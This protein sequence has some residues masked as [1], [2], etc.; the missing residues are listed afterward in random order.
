MDHWGDPWA[1]DSDD[2]N[3][4]QSPPKRDKVTEAIDSPPPTT[5][6]APVLLNAFLDDAQWGDPEED[7]DFGGWATSA[8][9]R[10]SNQ[11]DTRANEV[12]A[13]AFTVE[14]DNTSHY[15]SEAPKHTFEVGDEGWGTTNTTSGEEA[16]RDVDNVFSEA[17]D[18]ATTIQPEEPS[19]AI[20]ND[21]AS[22]SVRHGD[23]FSTRPSTS[24]SDTSHRDA[25]VE[26]PRTSFEDERHGTDVPATE[27]STHTEVEKEKDQHE[28]I[29]DVSGSEEVPDEGSEDNLQKV[30]EPELD[31]QEAVAAL[32]QTED[33]AVVSKDVTQQQA[34]QLDDDNAELPPFVI[35][36]NVPGLNVDESLLDK[37]FPPIP[38]LRGLPT[39][40]DDPVHSTSARKAW[41]RLTRK[42][43][44]REFN[45]STDDDNY[46]RITWKQSHIRSEVNKIVGRWATEDRLSG[47]GPA[48]AANFYW[49]QVPSSEP[50]VKSHVRRKSSISVSMVQ[51]SASNSATNIPP[52]F[53][54]SSPVATTNVWTHNPPSSQ[55][56]S[57]TATVKDSAPS[58]IRQ[59]D[60]PL[61]FSGSSVSTPAG[62]VKIASPEG[63]VSGTQLPQGHPVEA[64]T[65][66]SNPD[67]RS[68]LSQEITPNPVDD[69]DDDWG[70]MV[71]SPAVATFA[72]IDQFLDE[73]S[74]DPTPST[75]IS[76]PTS[77]TASPFEQATS[78]HSSPIVR[79][80]GT[81]SPTS[82]LF[83]YN[84]FVPKSS[85]QGPI[86][87]GML[88]KVSREKPPSVTT[89]NEA[90]PAGRDTDGSIDGV[91]HTSLAS[92][93]TA[94]LASP[95][96][97]FPTIAT[98]VEYHQANADS[99]P[100]DNQELPTKAP[101]SISDPWSNA[102]FSFFE[103]APPPQP[104][105]APTDPSDP[106]SIF[107]SSPPVPYT[108]PPT[109]SLT[110][111]PLQPLTGATNSAQRRKAE[112]DEIIR[113]IVQG[114]PNLS[115]M[116]H[117]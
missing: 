104:P 32:A 102:D 72:P 86:G 54:W 8:P 6:S 97:G 65:Q 18:S 53:N 47:R 7:G 51:H 45:N 16:L 61:V 46:V 101:E 93:T 41:Y 14:T 117:N 94:E 110:P 63:G 95:G 27:D 28:D 9:V 57:T 38:G 103:S 116:L 77:V 59:P 80:Q 52:A 35:V 50:V 31:N 76:T 17:S 64:S 91:I 20:P 1:D 98:T 90:T 30:P 56:E 29:L 49:D 99:S 88:R 111:P 82:A 105:Q 43:T 85:E 75:V 23:D 115:Y 89:T 5:T 22:D 114:L 71:Q 42:Q 37:L 11:P 55:G 113:S 109:K 68:A 74:Q 66:D 107:N 58:Q 87:P 12:D 67:G 108:R 70:D 73:S 96:S 44:L 40:P 84:S 10:S 21:S 112:E 69:D 39:P 3:N 48:A 36:P 79:L 83:R 13:T 19:Q 26:S 15:D 78:K 25:L 62:I 2:I 4:S 100:V 33:T 81:V 106:F 34:L 92:E 60:T 24:P